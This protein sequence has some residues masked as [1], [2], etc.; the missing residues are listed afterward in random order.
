MATVSTKSPTYIAADNG[1]RI[2]NAIAFIDRLAARFDDDA[3]EVDAGQFNPARKQMKY[4]GG[5]RAGT[6]PE[7]KGEAGRGRRRPKDKV[8]WSWRAPP[9][10]LRNPA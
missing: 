6:S 4:Q 10:G 9:K 8:N 3:V 7:Q 5:Q 1:D 2:G